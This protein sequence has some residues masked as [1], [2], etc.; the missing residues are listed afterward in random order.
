MA[1]STIATWKTKAQPM[2]TAVHEASGLIA[3]GLITGRV[4]TGMLHREQARLV[5]ASSWKA[6]ADSCRAV[7]FLPGGSV[8]VSASADGSIAAFD[9]SSGQAMARRDKAHGGNINTL[10]AVSACVLASGDDDGQVRVW[11]MRQADSVACFG[12]HT[13]YISAMT[14]AQEG[15]SLLATSGD[16]TLSVM[17]LRARK[18]STRSEDA[19]DELLCVAVVKGG[20]KV[21]CG[22]LNGPLP[23]Y[24]WGQFSDMS[25]RIPGHPGSVD[26]M[27]RLDDDTIV[28]GCA[29]GLLRAV[30]IFPNK[31]LCVLGRHSGQSVER[32]ALSESQRVLVSVGLGNSLKMWDLGPL[33]DDSDTSEPDDKSTQ[34]VNGALKAAARGAEPDSSGEEEEEEAEET[35]A[36]AGGLKRKQGGKEKGGRKSFLQANQS[37]GFFADLL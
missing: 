18:V 30:S 5:E 1:C 6:H 15:G 4:R 7:A 25:D 14:L 21:V 20:R 8:L 16:G 29:D 3:A 24:S 35:A 17:D 13:D 10:E 12:A 22:S 33:L 28:T 9:C 27:V 37:Q 31:L 34:Q 11:D 2:D 36:M 19:E 26:A 32:L 23:I